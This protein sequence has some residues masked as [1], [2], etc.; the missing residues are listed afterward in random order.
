MGE[1]DDVTAVATHR[2]AQVRP[3]HRPPRAPDEGSGDRRPRCR[4][5]V[6]IDPSLEEIQVTR[7]SSGAGWTVEPRR[8]LP[9]YPR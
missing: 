1:G 3:V 2:R 5:T 4:W 7:T 6:T 9:L 8:S